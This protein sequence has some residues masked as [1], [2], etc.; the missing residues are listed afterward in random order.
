M[1]LSYC[2]DV[3]LTSFHTINCEPGN[4]FVLEKN[5]NIALLCANRIPDNFDD[6]HDIDSSILSTGAIVGIVF[7][8]IILLALL[9][10]LGYFLRR[11]FNDKMWSG[12]SSKG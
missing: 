12:A 9:G 7:G 4:L 2:E 8:V 6:N 10:G 11:R 1:D 5:K 3:T